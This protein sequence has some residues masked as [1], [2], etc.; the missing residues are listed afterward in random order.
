MYIHDYKICSLHQDF[1]LNDA[2]N[3]D[4]EVGYLSS[5]IVEVV[6]R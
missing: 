2:H 3:A 5:I 4:K 6:K 1:W